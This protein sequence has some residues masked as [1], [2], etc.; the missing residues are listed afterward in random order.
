[1][2]EL[3]LWEYQKKRI[4]DFYSCSDSCGNQYP[5]C[6]GVTPN[7]CQLHQ[8]NNLIDV[9]NEPQKKGDKE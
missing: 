1:M 3:I 6:V 8:I 9:L 5:D 4:C 7:R 2:N